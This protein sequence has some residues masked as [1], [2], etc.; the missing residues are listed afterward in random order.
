MLSVTYCHPIA[1]QHTVVMTIVICL[2]SRPRTS[3]KS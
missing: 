2:S 1:D 3:A